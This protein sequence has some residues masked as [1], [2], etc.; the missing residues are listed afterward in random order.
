MNP[1][2]LVN[3]GRHAKS[4]FSIP[5][6]HCGSVS[7]YDRETSTSRLSQQSQVAIDLA[8]SGPAGCGG[9]FFGQCSCTNEACQEYTHFIGTFHIREDEHADTG[10]YYH[11]FVIKYFL[12]PVPLIRIPEG[13]PAPVSALLKRSFGPAFMDQ[14]ASVHVLRSAIE[15]LLTALGVPRFGMSKKRKRI[16]LNLHT[17]IER[18]PMAFQSYKD[19]LLAIKWIGNA[20]THEDISVEDLQ[21]LYEIVERLLERLYGTRDRELSRAIKRINQRKRP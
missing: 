21:L 17:R 11:E 6:P 20:A 4:P 14:A 1:F 13:T 16:R 9:T 18:L 19:E 7:T 5:C 3:A 12:P 15:K 10:Q 8:G 2:E